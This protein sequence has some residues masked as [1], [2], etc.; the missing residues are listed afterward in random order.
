MKGTARFLTP[1]IFLGLAGVPMSIPQ[2]ASAQV[3]WNVEPP[4][5]YNDVGR[6]A[7][8]DGLQA[9]HHDWDMHR[10]MDPY[11]YP[12]YRNPSVP[13][14]ERDHYRDAFLRGYDEGMHRA[15]GWDQDR[16][17]AWRDHDQDHDHDHDH[18]QY[19]H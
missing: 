19:P 12:Q 2:H 4:N 18:D 13:P 14:R 6:R 7:F 1:V 16:G 11:H 3:Q 17:N 10:E 9:A 5:Y 8:H 15:R